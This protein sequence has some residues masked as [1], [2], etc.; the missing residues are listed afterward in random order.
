MS[1]L[2]IRVQRGALALMVVAAAACSESAPPS[3]STAPAEDSSATGPLVPSFSIDGP[4]RYEGQLPVGGTLRRFVL[5]V[6]D[7]VRSPAPLVVV[8]HGF[9]ADPE[10]VESLSGFHL[11]G[12]RAGFVVAYPQAAG[13]PARW[14]TDA[15]L[16]SDADVEFVRALVALIEG[17]IAIDPAGVY[18]AGMSNGGG[19]ASRLA[20][21]AADL[22]AAVGSVS[23][24]HS[25]GP[26][27]PARPVPVAEF[28]G[29]A[30]VIVP[31]EG[32]PHVLAAADAW[33]EAWAERNGCS[34][35][36]VTRAVTDD[37]DLLSWPG[38]AASVH[39]YRITGGGHGWPGSERASLRGDSTMSI[40]ASEYL[41]R[42][43]EMHPLR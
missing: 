15:R 25:E 34:G 1:G 16:Q 31:Y 39:L 2:V 8:L 43:F 17:V 28:H 11:L 23:G 29:T 10:A 41:W 26:C 30:D 22:F 5:W 18:A 33:A 6:P 40:D 12:E 42:F 38:C 24:A 7:S 13:R 20:C 37:V 21:D 14:R 4:G 36:E 19:M 32:W 27:R 35:P 9:G 3:S